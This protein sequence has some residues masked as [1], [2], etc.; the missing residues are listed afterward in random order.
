MNRCLLGSQ[1]RIDSYAQKAR[2]YGCTSVQ[3]LNSLTTKHFCRSA[4]ELGLEVH[5]FYADE[6]IEMLHLFNQEQYRIYIMQTEFTK[7]I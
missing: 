6:Q 5:P 1:G 4:K 7:L 2:D 3:P